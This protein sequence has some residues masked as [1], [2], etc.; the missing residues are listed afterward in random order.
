MKKSFQPRI[1]RLRQ[2]A[3]PLKLQRAKDYG[4]AG[5]DSADMDVKRKDR[6][7]RPTVRPGRPEICAYSRVLVI[8]GRNYLSCL[9]LRLFEVIAGVCAA[10]PRDLLE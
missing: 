6:G 5:T 2:A 9:R 7:Q 4:M 10:V 1:P 3:L 8:T